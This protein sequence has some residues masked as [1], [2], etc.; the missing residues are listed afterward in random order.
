MR[1]KLFAL[2]EVTDEN[3]KTNL[4]Y[5]FYDIFMMIMIVLSI[6]PLAF[7]EEMPL[8]VWIDRVAVV[9]FIIDYILRLFTADLKLKKGVKS[10]FLYPF[11]PMAVVDLLSILPS[12]SLLNPGFRVLRITRLARTLRIF[13]IFKVFRYS[14]HVAIL[15]EVFKRQKD[16]LLAV[17]WL[18]LV[19]I[20]ISSLVVFNVE[21]E[22]FETFFDAFYWATVSLTTVGYGDI[23]PTSMAGQVVTM[24]SS[25]MGIAV[26]ALPASI[27]TAGYMEELEEK[28]E[29]SKQE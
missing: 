11:T 16:S 8:F 27:I 12:L 10:Y 29:G 5:D 14:R 1:K 4:V 28:E 6:I 20:L 21:P 24:I 22:T 18:A 25:I 2:L 13:R 19:Y 17:V 7:K 23:Y 9:V 26:V 15:I 3:N